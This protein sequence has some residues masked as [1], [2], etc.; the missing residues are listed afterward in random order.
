MKIY[1]DKKTKQQLL[2]ANE[3][4]REVLPMGRKKLG[5]DGCVYCLS[6][7]GGGLFRAA[8]VAYGGSQARGPIEATAAGLHLNHSNAGSLT[9]TEPGQGSNLQ[10]H[11]S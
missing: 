9:H 5:G 3:C 4:H 7:F 1:S 10:P 8:P 6:F 2:E 11:G